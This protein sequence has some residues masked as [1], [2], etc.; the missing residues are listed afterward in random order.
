M[1][2][3]NT[4]AIIEDGNKVLLAMKKRGFGEGW[5]NGY[6]G[7]LKDGE[8]V[9]EALVRELKEESGLLAKSYKKRGVIDFYFQ[10]NDNEIEMHIFEVTDYEGNPVETEEMAP[11]WFLR[12]E[13]PYN[14]MWPADRQWMPLY[15]DG[16]N[17]EGH[18]VFNGGTNELIE[19]DFKPVRPHD[20]KDIELTLERKPKLK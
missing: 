9:E 20:E 19:S 14:K 17:V 6:G 18:A 3:I 11:K 16:H 2:L 4:L 15:F 13:I 12:D 10:D 1:K 8:T 5:W 7:K